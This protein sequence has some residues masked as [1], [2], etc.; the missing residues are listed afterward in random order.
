MRDAILEK[1]R[2]EDIMTDEERERLAKNEQE[3]L[4]VNTDKNGM[5]K[6]EVLG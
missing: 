4:Y 1:Y 3:D 5:K 6:I 2:P